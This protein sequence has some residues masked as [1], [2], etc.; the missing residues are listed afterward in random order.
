MSK[1]KKIRKILAKNIL[2]ERGLC[3]SLDEA[4]TLILAGLALANDQRIAKP[5]DLIPEDANV[6]LKKKRDFVSRGGTKLF[7]AVQE[8]SLQEDFRNTLVLDV[9]ASTGGFTDCALQLGARNVLALDVG[10]NQ[11]HWSLRSDTRVINLERTDIRDFNGKDYA[12]FDWIIAD[13]SFNSLERLAPD[14]LRL[15][16]P[17]TKFLILVKPQ[18]ELLKSE[19]PKGGVVESKELWDKALAK[20]SQSFLERGARNIRY[21]KSAIKGRRGNQEF[22][23]YCLA[24]T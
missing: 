12:P 4:S 6:R 3:A 15:A 19:V 7:N 23:M 14:L 13:V 24:P 8:L 22:F 2:V 9:G 16:N 21:A 1:P 20:V 11:L 17:N 10:T 5:G 18:F